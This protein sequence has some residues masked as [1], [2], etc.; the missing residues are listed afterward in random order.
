MPE[1]TQPQRSVNY[2]GVDKT[3][4]S[5]AGL[6][7]SKHTTC[8]TVRPSKPL[9]FRLFVASLLL[10]T[11][12]AGFCWHSVVTE[13]SNRPASSKIAANKNRR[14]R[15]LLYYRSLHKQYH[16]RFTQQLEELA[17][18]CERQGLVQAAAQIRKQITPFQPDLLDFSP[19][20]E[21]VHSKLDP[22]K[23]PADRQWQAQLQTLCNQYAQ[24]LYM[25]SRRVLRAGF[26]SYAYTLICQVAHYNP[27]HLQ[28]RRL[29]GYER[30]KGRWVTPFTAYMLRRHYVWS[31]RF[32]WLPEKHLP[33]Y[34][35]GERYFQGWIS[36]A[37]EQKLRSDFRRAWQIRTE[38]YLIRT[39]YSLEGGVEMAR[40]LEFFHQYLRQSLV[41][42][43]YTPQQLQRLFEGR[44]SNRVSLPKPHVVYFFRTKSEYV[45]LLQDRIPQAGI[46]N[47]MYIP[48]DRIVYTYYNPDP[49]ADMRGTLFHEST[50][51]LLFESLVPPH[52]IADNANFWAIEGIACYMESAELG[53][54]GIVR[55][56]NPG[57]SRFQIA[58]YRYVKDGFYIPL[59][60]FT[61]MGKDEFQHHPQIARLYTQAA[62]LTYF[63]LHYDG[64]KYKDAFV[65]FLAQIY[66]V[67]S[68]RKPTRVQS[69]A[70]L[71]G[72]SF[73][74]LDKQYGQFMRSLPNLLPPGATISD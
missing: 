8:K 24:E 64:G 28:A 60:Q 25:L 46:T 48:E 26:P 1:F 29:L 30:Y 65:Q 16:R 23:L 2:S 58:R 43:F 72:V 31:D 4:D 47:G 11:F 73:E 71:T 70:E 6:Q 32:G 50:H 39:N 5:M 20:P 59:A 17:Q 3:F 68:R 51:Q 27:D 10:A 45:Q 18:A 14:Y 19:L 57:Y 54:K 33:R 52:P 53:P 34:E 15:Q 42:F 37:E 22:S 41:A 9:G 40:A 74:E 44:A 67:N 12:L 56:G 13:A 36:A 38:H 66:G 62:G 55:V 7:G 69:L 21:Q 61:R 35:R 49:S 63:F